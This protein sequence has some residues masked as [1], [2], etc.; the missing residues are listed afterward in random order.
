[1]FFYLILPSQDLIDQLNDAME[2]PM[3]ENIST[4][5]YELYELTPL[6]KNTTNHFFFI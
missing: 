1:M 5:Y 2:N 3:S 6:M 4:N